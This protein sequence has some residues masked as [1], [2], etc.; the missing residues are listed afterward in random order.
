VRDSAIHSETVV[1]VKVPAGIG[2]GWDGL[3]LNN[4]EGLIV[5]HKKLMSF[6]HEH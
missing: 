5:L 2:R 6:L 4:D 1:S 3:L